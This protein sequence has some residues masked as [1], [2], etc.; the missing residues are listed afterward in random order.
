[1]A[2]ETGDCEVQSLYQSPSL[3]NAR[4]TSPFGPLGEYR[5]N[6]GT[7]NGSAAMRVDV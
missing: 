5:A 4:R 6:M 7:W 2:Q 3:L 1:M